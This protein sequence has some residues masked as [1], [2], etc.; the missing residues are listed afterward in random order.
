MGS[1]MPLLSNAAKDPRRGSVSCL[2][3]NLTV[4]MLMRILTASHKVDCAVYCSYFG[5][6]AEFHIVIGLFRQHYLLYVRNWYSDF[7]TRVKRSCYGHRSCA[8][9][10][11]PI[12]RNQAGAEE[13]HGISFSYVLHAGFLRD[14]FLDL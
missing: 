4:E 9:L 8:E 14:L 12:S 2:V 5:R 11:W 7:R 1:D 13:I 6:E 10:I 3:R